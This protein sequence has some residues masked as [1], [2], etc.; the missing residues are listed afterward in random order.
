MAN[1]ADF[2]SKLMLLLVVD[3]ILSIFRNLEWIKTCPSYTHSI[4]L[5]NQ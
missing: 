4:L 2:S 3:K 1:Y 5:Q